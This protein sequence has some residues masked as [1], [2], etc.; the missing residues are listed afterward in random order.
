MTAHRGWVNRDMITSLLSDLRGA[1]H[2]ARELTARPFDDLG[3]Y[4]RLA[5]RY[6]VIELVEA[7]AVIC[8]HLLRALYYVEVEGYPHCFLR[9]GEL[10]LIPARLAERLARAARLRNLVVHRYWVID[11]RR[12]YEEVKRGLSDFEEYASTVEGVLGG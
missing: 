7:S 9:M 10:G 11:D 2:R 1:M 3:V 6:L 8:V 5:L 4:E 12:L